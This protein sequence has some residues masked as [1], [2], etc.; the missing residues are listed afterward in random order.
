LVGLAL[1][2]KPALNYRLVVAE[3]TVVSWRQAEI[4]L[5]QAVNS[6]R[7]IGLSCEHYNDRMP[8]DAEAVKNT[9]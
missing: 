9:A 7:W 2:A 6:R 5:N 4:P 1:L 3:S 8:D